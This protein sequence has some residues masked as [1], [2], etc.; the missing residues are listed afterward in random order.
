MNVRPPAVSGM[1]YPGQPAALRSEVEALLAS[2][3]VQAPPPK[4]LIAPHAG[5]SYSGP[6]AATAYNLLREVAARIS[7]V[8]VLGPAH[9]VLQGLA[10]PGVDA[11]ETPL[12]TIPLDA[13]AMSRVRDLPQVQVSDAA[14]RQEHSLEVHLPFLQMTLD[15][16]SLVP[17]V[18]GRATPE[19][20]SQV[21][22]ILWGGP[23]TL[24]V[25]ST[26]LSHYHAYDCA[27]EID[28]QTNRLLLQRNTHITGEQACGAHA[29]NGLMLSATQR[30]LEVREL[31]LRNSGDTAGT[32]DQVVGYA[33]YALYES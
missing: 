29:I 24:I 21:L 18:V 7:R 28:A 23:E 14:H 26:D 5:Y 20:V 22:E 31:D 15:E 11:F 25:V 3:S 12:G 27:M 9:R 30:G 32:R 4:V 6:V 8:V 17:F 33:S 13:E 16:F 10:L 2:N 1:F 19:E